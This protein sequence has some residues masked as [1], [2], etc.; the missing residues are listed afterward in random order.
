VTALE[1]RNLSKRY[2]ERLAVDDL[3]FTVDDGALACVVGPSGCG[4]TTVLRSVAG[5]LAPDSGRIAI[6]G[7]VVFSSSPRVAVRAEDRRTGLVFQD[8]ALW[9]HMNVRQ[10]LRFPMESRGLPRSQREHEVSQLLR[11]VQM[12]ELADRRPSELSGGQQQR[13]ALARALACGPRLL[14]MDEPM[15]NL[16]ARLRQQMRSDLVRLLRSSGAAT[17]YVTHDQTEAMSIADQIIV[18]R[19]GRLIQQGTPTSV[20]ERPADLGVADFL[21]IGPAIDAEPGNEPQ[22]ALLAGGFPVT[23]SAFDLSDV[24]RVVV[25]VSAVHAA[26]PCGTGGDELTV[27]AVVQTTSYEGGAW[28]VQA[29]IGAGGEAIHFRSDQPFAAGQA[30]PLHLVSQRLLAFTNEGSLCPLRSGQGS[31]IPLSE[32]PA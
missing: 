27:P 13:V 10:H 24:A 21:N 17:L 7:R 12:E 6:G 11:L 22:M 15:S 32:V 26:E 8:Y 16:D 20:Y 18:L 23:M 28:L 4:K 5:L 19:D 29:G 9:P 1:I 14:L 31:A 25:P 2:G 30:V 3:S